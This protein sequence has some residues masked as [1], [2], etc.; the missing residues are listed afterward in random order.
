MATKLKININHRN[1]IGLLGNYPIVTTLSD[2]NGKLGN[3]VVTLGNGVLSVTPA[4]LT[5]NPSPTARQYGLPNPPFVGT[6]SGFET[7]TRLRLRFHLQ[8]P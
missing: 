6:L 7:R 8:P 2:P 4:V 1:G 3:Y 5:V